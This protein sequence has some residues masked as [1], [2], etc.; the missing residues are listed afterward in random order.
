LEPV[1]D[2]SVKATL[3]DRNVKVTLLF[4][5][6]GNELIAS[7]RA[8]ARG[9]TVAG[10]VAPTPWEARCWDDAVRDGVLVPLDG[11]VVRLLAEEPKPYWRGRISGLVRDYVKPRGPGR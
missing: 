11:E 10:T 3:N 9:R 8:D 2:T 1:A 4:R 7:A 5:F 6:D